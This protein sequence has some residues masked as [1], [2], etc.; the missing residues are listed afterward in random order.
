M[1]NPDPI[2]QIG[3]NKCATSAFFRLFLKAGNKALHSGGRYWRLRD[4]KAIA[5]KNPQLEI[6]NNIEHGRPPIEGFE[7]FDSFFDM[8]FV[9][10]EIPIENFRRFEKFAIAYPQA[11]FL[12]NTRKK[13]DWLRSRARHHDGLYLA[14]A[15][16]HYKLERSDILSKWSDDFDIHHQKVREFFLN[17]NDRL[18]DFDIDKSDIQELVNFVGPERAL[19]ETDW[20]RVRVTDKVAA[21]KSWKDEENNFSYDSITQGS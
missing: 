12:L 19:N 4:H 3:F 17:E 11:K 7:D 21:A 18:L 8:E 15:M 6:H 1:Q 14:I 16:S 2:F 5:G 20:K 10:G 13:E 9:H